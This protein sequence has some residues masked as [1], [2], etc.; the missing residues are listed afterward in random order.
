MVIKKLKKL[1]NGITVNFEH[2]NVLYVLKENDV[3]NLKTDDS[4][5]D[6]SE[7]LEPVDLPVEIIFL[8]ILYFPM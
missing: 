8:N 2:Q 7:F 5:E 1:D 4:I 6:T 3:L